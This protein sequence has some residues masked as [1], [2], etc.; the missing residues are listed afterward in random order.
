MT[1]EQSFKI[2]D[3]VRLK[4]GGPKMTID[5]FTFNH[6]TK[7]DNKDIVECVWFDNLKLNREIFNVSV[8]IIE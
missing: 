3:V 2:G 6:A 8:L 1:N 7:K 5:R 4:S